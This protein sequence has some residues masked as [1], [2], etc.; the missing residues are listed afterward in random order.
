MELP[1]CLRQH[2]YWC[3]STASKLSRGQVGSCPHVCVSICTF[4][5]V[6]QVNQ[7]TQLSTC[8]GKRHDYERELVE[9]CSICT[10]VLVKQVNQQPVPA[11]DMTTSASSSSLSQCA[12]SLPAR[13]IS[14][15]IC[16]FVLATRVSICTFV[17]RARRAWRSAHAACQPRISVSICTFVLVR[18]VSIF[19]F[20]LVKQVSICTSVLVRQVQILTLAV[21]QR[22]VAWHLMMLLSFSRSRITLHIYIYIQIDIT[23]IILIDIL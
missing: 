12:C 9:L 16:T 4:V 7:Q 10:F 8:A 3:T 1:A 20:V 23:Y 11:S 15:S 22:S 18:Q 6:K 14:V 19:T 21:Y 13:R 17:A 5:L 2:L